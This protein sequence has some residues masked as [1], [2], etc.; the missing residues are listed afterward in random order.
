M[1]LRLTRA[2]ARDPGRHS[3]REAPPAEGR[4]SNRAWIMV[5]LVLV[6]AGVT[7]LVM[8]RRA[9]P[10]VSTLPPAQLEGEPDVYMDS[11][12]VAQYHPNGT[13]EY[14]LVARRASHYQPQALTRLQ[15]PHLTLYR[16]GA[17]P[18]EARARQGVLRRPPAGAPEEIVTLDQDVLLEQSQPGGEHLRLSTPALRLYPRRQYAE[19]DRDV[20]IESSFGR[21]YA[22][23]LEGDLKNGVLYLRSADGGRVRTVLQP[24]QFK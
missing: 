21:T 7:L 1:A 14:R 18:W 10:P 3:E 8:E 22:E 24:D 11:P 16:T 4:R 19:T 13:L 17:A 6:I 20:M 9:G 5:V 12:V 15:D 2:G 23:G